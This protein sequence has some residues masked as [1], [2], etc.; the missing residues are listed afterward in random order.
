[1]EQQGKLLISQLNLYEKQYGTFPTPTMYPSYGLKGSDREPD[2]ACLVRWENGEASDGL[3]LF[4]HLT[5]EYDATIQVLFW[6]CPEYYYT[7]IEYTRLWIQQINRLIKEKEDEYNVEESIMVYSLN[8]KEEILYKIDE[9][10]E[11]MES[12]IDTRSFILHRLVYN[13]PK[14]VGSIILLLYHGKI[15]KDILRE[16]WTYLR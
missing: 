9:T 2:E 3:R 1:M 11:E 6:K 16:L 15:H 4:A 7:L 10:I 5:R 8:H 12:E 14:E 13:L